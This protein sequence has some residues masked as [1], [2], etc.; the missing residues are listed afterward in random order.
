MHRISQMRL[1]RAWSTLSFLPPPL[2][3]SLLPVPQ[4]LWT[5]TRSMVLPMSQSTPVA[6]FL[7]A[8]LFITSICAQETQTGAATPPDDSRSLEDSRTIGRQR[9]NL[10]QASIPQN[11]ESLKP[12]LEEFDSSIRPILEQSCVAC[13]GEDLQEGNIRIDTLDPDL[14]HGNDIDWWLEVQAVLST[15][16]MP[17][18][19][20]AELAD[21]DRAMVVEWLS[22]EIQAASIV[23]R[24]SGDQSSF[25]RMTRYEFNYA[26]QDLLGLPY[27]F[28]KDLS[29]EANSEDGFQNSSEVLHISVSQLETYRRLARNALLKATVR[30]ERPPVL[31]WGVT[32]QD[33]GRIEWAQQ[34]EHFEKVRKETADDP[35]AQEKKLSELEKQISQPHPGPY[36]RN[37]ATGRTVRAHWQ[38][39]HA[40]HANEAQEMQRPIP[41]TLEHVAILP[42]GGDR[43]FTIELGNQVPDEGMMRVRVR[44]SRAQAED[45]DGPSL[46]LLFGWQ[47]SNEGRAVLPVPDGERVVTADPEQSEFLQ[48]DVPLGEIYPRNSVRK[49]ST[50]GAMPNPSEYIRLVND[51]VSQGAIR[52][53]YVEVQAPVYDEW[54]PASHK[55]IFIDSEHR[56]DEQQYS[57][58]VILAFMR[59]AWRRSIREEE[60][61]RKLQLFEAMR[62]T[63]DT[64]DE[65]VI[66][67]LATV[68]AS[69]QFLYVIGEGAD[70]PQLDGHE[71]ATRLS[72]F[73]WCSIPDEELS[74]L[75]QSGE[76]QNEPVLKGQ[77][78]RMLSD[79]RSARLARHFVHQ[80]LDM[81]L[82][83]FRS[84]PRELESLREAMQQEPVAVF[85]EM[86][87]TDASVLDFLHAEYTLVNERLAQHYGLPN[88]T[89]NQFRRVSLDSDHRRGGL[90]TQA[91][92][93]A[94]NSAGDDSHPLKRG[95]WLLESLL[96]DP[97]P[98]PPP[99]VPEIDL[100]DPE[101]AKLTLKE[102]IE[103]HR[104]HA[105][106][107]SCHAK[108]DPWGIAF[109]NYDA[110]GRWRDQI[111]KKPVDAT[112]MLFNRQR[113]DGMQGLKRYLLENR[114]DQ[115]VRALV[116]K[117]TTYAL[118]RPLTF[119]DR[120][121]VDKI[122]SNV[123]QQGDGLATMITMIATSDLF[124]ANSGSK[125]AAIQS[126]ENENQP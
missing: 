58:E 21:A 108:I 104:N 112:S 4:S 67:V 79:D 101:I 83:E 23:R 73:L 98:P 78:A 92:L 43:R 47:A 60:L 119:A 18:P 90:L 87:Q 106:C 88:V 1:V 114:Q 120:A 86:L 62:P 41:E 125:S 46:Q 77:V 35:A 71:L 89:G 68:L 33:A 118:G 65:A 54:P 38:Y 105:A 91:G 95:V 50:M 28:A 34:N 66:E 16:E 25:R 102:Q 117:L 8:V 75:A 6:L 14:L 7:T 70:V 96:N 39:Y 44:A 37:L 94:M 113:L 72:M 48:W 3:I 36:F 10:G 85:S 11:T 124:R 107:R 19:D 52:I 20:D 29:P 22:N 5:M 76:L 116:H 45:P 64:F 24:A 63:C 13:H 123:R 42:R 99:A 93:L 17:P 40:K 49:T 111:D 126:P 53:E 32:M 55:R 51:S 56:N 103:V 59:R 27:S 9:S 2:T 109:E 84:M 12:K 115:F 57:R 100:A 30:G 81:Q 110:L 69:P 80:W 82:L 15:G 121:A 26:L 31:H 74:Q 61:D 97:P 122:T